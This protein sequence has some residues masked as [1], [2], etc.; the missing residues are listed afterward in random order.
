MWITSRG[1]VQSDPDSVLS[2]LQELLVSPYVLL[3]NNIPVVRCT[4][5]PGEFII[6]YPGLA[7]QH[8]LRA[9]KSGIMHAI[10]GASA[11]RQVASQ[12]L[13]LTAVLLLVQ[14]LT[15]QASTMAST[16]LS[17]PTLRQSRG[18]QSGCRPG[19]VTARRTA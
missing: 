9:L 14:G 4:Q 10:L 2:C 11:A 17:L 6:N 5:F 18:C 3:Q 16:A 13:R 15:T 7:H 12:Y 8:E 1:T 19:T